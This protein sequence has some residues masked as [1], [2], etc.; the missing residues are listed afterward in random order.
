MSG[1]VAGGRK[2]AITNKKKYGDDFYKR[3]G[4]EGGKVGTT[5]GF[6]QNR[7]LARIAGSKA[8]KISKHGH[9][10]LGE[11]N[12]VRKY[13]ARATGMV[14]EYHYDSESKKYVRAD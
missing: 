8:G 9:M 5:G 11:E 3:I 14:V 13:L 2:A 1:T 7:E 12:G 10:Y 4:A 6:Y